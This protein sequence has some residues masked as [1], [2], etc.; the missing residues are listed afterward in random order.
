MQLRQHGRRKSRHVK[1]Q[2]NNIIKKEMFRMKKYEFSNEAYKRRLRK[3][4][5]NPAFRQRIKEWEKVVAEQ[6]TFDTENEALR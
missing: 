2:I 1:E 5:T 6:P 4:R 3:E